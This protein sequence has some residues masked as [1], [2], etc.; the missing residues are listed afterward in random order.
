MDG[1]EGGKRR[2]RWWR[3]GCCQLKA[4]ANPEAGAGQ[5]SIAVVQFRPTKHR[6]REKR[7]CWTSSRK[8]GEQGILHNKFSSEGLRIWKHALGGHRAFLMRILGEEAAAEASSREQVL[9]QHPALAVLVVL[10][11]SM[12]HPCR[13]MQLG[14]NISDDGLF[15][16]SRASSLAAVV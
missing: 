7:S 11:A 15:A 13:Q 9:G 6:A 2:T 10:G 5:Q 12:V 1:S 8:K 3:S 4:D 16:A 14:A